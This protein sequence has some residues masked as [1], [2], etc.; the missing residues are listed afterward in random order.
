MITPEITEYDDRK[1]IETPSATVI[2]YDF[3]GV[4]YRRRDVIDKITGRVYT[5]KQGFLQPNEYIGKATD[6]LKRQEKKRASEGKYYTRVFHN[7]RR[8]P[9]SQLAKG[10]LFDLITLLPA[11]NPVV[12]IP[13][14]AIPDLMIPA[15]I[16]SLARYLDVDKMTIHRHLK[17]LEE[18]GIIK[19]VKDSNRPTAPAII[20]VNTNL[21][22]NGKMIIDS[23][24]QDYFNEDNGKLKLSYYLDW[25]ETPKHIGASE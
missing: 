10:T 14:E 15:N 20:V 8:L 1:V 25:K 11:D 2:Y 22:F 12:S 23:D 19:L 7:A 24:L 6:S 3:D 4:N 9:V 18:H 21:A 13:D 17:E 16:N 5:Q